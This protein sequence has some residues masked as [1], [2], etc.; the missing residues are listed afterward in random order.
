MTASRIMTPVLPAK[1]RDPREHVLET[2]AEMDEQIELL[3]KRKVGAAVVES[4]AVDSLHFLVKRAR[5]DIRR[6]A[7]LGGAH[8]G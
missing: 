7:L 3:R 8:H 5:G 1:A 4:A 6:L 2:L